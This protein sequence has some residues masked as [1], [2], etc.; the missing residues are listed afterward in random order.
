MDVIVVLL[1]SAHSR[2]SCQR[3][4]V[5]QADSSDAFD[6]FKDLKSLRFVAFPSNVCLGLIPDPGSK[7]ILRR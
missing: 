5:F 1:K 6:H 2:D 7:S 4:F 3:C